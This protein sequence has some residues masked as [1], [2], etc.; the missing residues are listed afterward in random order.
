[1][2]IT[3]NNRRT[4]FTS[5]GNGDAFTVPCWSKRTL[6]VLGDDGGGTL[7][8]QTA[9]QLNE[10]DAE[11]WQ[12]FPSASWTA[13][14]CAVFDIPAGRYRWKLSGGAGPYALAAA[15]SE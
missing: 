2:T 3:S 11:E 1:M 6:S 5:V 13:E 7:V 8:L 15:M 9:V 4:K 12:D 10:T 14:A